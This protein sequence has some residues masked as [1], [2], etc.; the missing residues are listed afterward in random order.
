M[1]TKD[2]KPTN[3][4]GSFFLHDGQKLNK[5]KSVFINFYLN[6][7]LGKTLKENLLKLIFKHKKVVVQKNHQ[8]LLRPPSELL[9]EP[10]VNA[11]VLVEA[12]VLDAHTGERLANRPEVRLIST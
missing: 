4:T 7:L 3:Y 5:K 2:A 12:G 11:P 1:T 8:V 9:L 6:F 10:V